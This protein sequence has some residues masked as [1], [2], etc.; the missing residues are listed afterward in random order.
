[1][2]VFAFEGMHS[3]SSGSRLIAGHVCSSLF[4]AS[5]IEQWREFTEFDVL[6]T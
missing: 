3:V 2:A 5:I 4:F 6:T 1:V